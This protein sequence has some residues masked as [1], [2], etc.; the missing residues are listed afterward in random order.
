M[1]SCYRPEHISCASGSIATRVVWSHFT[2]RR[3]HC[4][5]GP[6]LWIGSIYSVIQPY[7]SVRRAGEH[8][9]PQ[10]RYPGDVVV[11]DF[12]T[13]FH[14][15]RVLLFNAMPIDSRFSSWDISPE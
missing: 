2:C 12:I 10:L 8:S 7:C 13:S 1:T 11:F 3:G 4:F 15:E 6:A 14:F 9:N 5:W